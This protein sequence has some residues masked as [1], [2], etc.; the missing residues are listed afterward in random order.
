MAR[1]DLSK[2][3]DCLENLT[4]PDLPQAILNSRSYPKV[5][6]AACYK[7]STSS[8]YDHAGLP[9]NLEVISKSRP[10]C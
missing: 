6:L 8:D 4:I 1:A 5:V 9:S 3:F 7:T 10:R 2:L